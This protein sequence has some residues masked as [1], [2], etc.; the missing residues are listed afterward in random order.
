MCGQEG[1]IVTPGESLLICLGFALK[2]PI[3][4]GQLGLHI[5]GSP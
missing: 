1:G 5:K 2:N 3:L 4:P